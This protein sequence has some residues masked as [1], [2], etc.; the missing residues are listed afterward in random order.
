MEKH[1]LWHRVVVVYMSPPP[2]VIF[3]KKSLIGMDLHHVLDKDVDRVA[4][5]VLGEHVK[6]IVKTISPARITRH[7]NRGV[8]PS[9]DVLL[10]FFIV[11]SIDYE[12]VLREMKI[13]FSKLFPRGHVRC[14]VFSNTV[15]MR[16]TLLTDDVLYNAVCRVGFVLTDR[17]LSVAMMS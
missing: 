17:W 4:I 7:L 16:E 13:R 2:V 12:D 3:L 14:S 5:G 11:E 15:C 8:N 6:T 9:T 1:H 10:R